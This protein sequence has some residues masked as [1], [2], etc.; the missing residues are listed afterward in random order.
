MSIGPSARSGRENCRDGL[1]GLA[2]IFTAGIENLTE[3]DT[4]S[5]FQPVKCVRR[6]VTVFKLDLNAQGATHGFCRI[7]Q[8][9]KDEIARIVQDSPPMVWSVV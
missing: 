1:V 2:E 9:G 6:T 5:I 3:I 7:V 8:D 4:D